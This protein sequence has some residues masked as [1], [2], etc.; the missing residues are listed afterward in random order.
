M[1]AGYPGIKEVSKENFSS[2][3]R[4]LFL[5]KQKVRK[6][7]QWLPPPVQWVKLNFDRSVRRNGEATGRGGLLRNAGGKC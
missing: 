6:S 5:E 7:S 2:D 4:D 1:D 3:L